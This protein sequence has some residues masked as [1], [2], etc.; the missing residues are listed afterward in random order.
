MD[1][2]DAAAK[3]YLSIAKRYGSSG[4]LWVWKDGLGG[5]RGT[6]RMSGSGESLC[7]VLTAEEVEAHEDWEP[8][9]SS[10]VDPEDRPIR[11]RHKSGSA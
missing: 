8:M 11:H 9:M 10:D 7:R 1:A 6:G 3:S 5:F 2:R 4:H